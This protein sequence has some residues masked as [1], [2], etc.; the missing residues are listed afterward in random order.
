MKIPQAP[1][2]KFLITVPFWKGDKNQA[3]WMT[4]LLADLE[5]G[6]SDKADILFVNRFD[7]PPMSPAFIK[8][9]A[10]K[11][12]VFQHRSA[13]KETGWPCGCNGLFFGTLEFVYHKMAAGQIPNYKAMFNMASDVVPL[14]KNWLAHM[15]DAWNALQQSRR[16]VCA[17]ALI[18]GDHPHI[19]GDAFFLSGLELLR[20]LTKEV[21][22]VKVRAGW[23]WVLAP[24]FRDRG[25]ANIPGIISLW[26][27]PTMP[28]AVAEDYRRKGIILIHG[29]KDDS[30]LTHAR[31]I[32]L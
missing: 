17:G 30:L 10:R 1:S 6:H 14:Q 25:W 18:D 21:G 32:L 9:V 24:N 8:Y 20:W 26:Q 11:F 31:N 23:D 3:E 16:V 7:C 27:T 15:H 28:R 5:P 13:R 2:N 12:N 19:N 22:G 4:R 29:V